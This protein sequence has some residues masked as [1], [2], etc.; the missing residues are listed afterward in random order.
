ML[1]IFNENKPI[2]A[3]LWWSQEIKMWFHFARLADMHF[4]PWF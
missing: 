1:D 2:P 4:E 3:E